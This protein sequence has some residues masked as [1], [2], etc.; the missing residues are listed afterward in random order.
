MVR[1]DV[2]KVAFLL[3]LL[4]VPA[5]EAQLWS[6]PAAVEVRVEGQK[7]LPVAGAR[8]QLRSTAVEPEDG[9]PPAVTDSRGRAVVSG[10][11][12][13]PWKL[14][15][16]QEG[17]MT[18]LAEITVSETSRPKVG[19]AN[20]V[21]VPGALRTLRVEISR[22]RSEPQAVRA[23]REQP[24]PAPAPAP[25][26]HRETPPRPE[27][28]PAPAPAEPRPAPAP[29]RETPRE[30]PRPP[31]PA[32][33]PI[34]APEPAPRPT[35]TPAPAS[36]PPPAADSLRMRSFEDRTC[37]ECQPG[38][39][40]LSTERVV[41]PGG[42]T[43]CGDIASQLQGG[44]VPSGLPAGCH[45]LRIAVPSGGRY[46]GYRFE[47]QDGG[48]TLDCRAGQDCPQG[49]GRWPGNPILVRGSGGTIVLA[50][51][52]AGP[53]DRERRAVLTVYFT[54]SKRL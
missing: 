24:A 48:A 35:P 37:V 51:F 49:T 1:F 12:A 39:S 17:Y 28:A 11:A 50:P 6:G 46:L 43:G 9:P 20:Q 3:L 5:A 2:R 30:T 34:P 4:A 7:G 38:E 8:V 42:G 27:P 47:V 41:P 53:A 31:A 18:Y 36:P 54:T 19:L 25:V 21:N 32:A 16:S 40:S 45:V 14:E 29:P 33:P 26:P 23:P 13:G 15:V 22:G 10:L 44:D 52:E